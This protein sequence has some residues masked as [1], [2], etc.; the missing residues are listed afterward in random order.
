MN[1]GTLRMGYAL[2]LVVVA[3]WAGFVLVSRLGG[4]GTLQPADIAALRFGTATLVLAPVWLFWRRVPLFNLRML[5]LAL[6]GGVA[7]SL[8]VYSGFRL[9]P[10]S[11]GALLVSGMLPFTMALWVWLVLGEQPSPQMRRGL[12]LIG[13]G[14][15]ALGVE[16]FLHGDY[17]T[18]IALGDALLVG[19]SLCWAFYTALVRRWGYGPWDTTIG[20]ALLAAL[21]YLPLYAF[22]RPD[23]IVHADVHEVILQGI[24]QGVLVLIVAMVLYMQAMVRLGPARLGAMMATVPAVSGIGASLWLGEPLTGW[25][26]AGLLLTSLGAWV[27]VRERAA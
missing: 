18:S 23:A 22:L 26:V 27:G 14:V 1:T 15:A 21:L 12:L 10:V 24:Y 13:T 6:V 5:A 19:A 17:S 20:V 9:A 8:T 25:I 7:Y 16:A 3:L 4:T 11:H 2:A